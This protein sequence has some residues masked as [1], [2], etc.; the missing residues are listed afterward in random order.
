MFFTSL[1]ALNTL[2]KNLLLFYAILLLLAS[3]YWS[4]LIFACV[5]GYKN[6]EQSV[7]IWRMWH[8][9]ASL[10]HVWRFASSAY[11]G[12]YVYKHGARCA[13]TGQTKAANSANV[14]ICSGGIIIT[15]PGTRYNN[16]NQHVLHIRAR[17]CKPGTKPEREREME[18][19]IDCAACPERKKAPKLMTQ[20]KSTS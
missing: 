17:N 9:H 7:G 15:H 16:K 19:K 14:F 10:Q 1:K 13:I 11:C 8:K 3:F 2:L 12:A 5:G 4:I 20:I 6:L 18:T